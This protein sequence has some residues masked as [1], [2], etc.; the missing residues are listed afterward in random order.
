[1]KKFASLF[2]V[3]ALTIVFPACAK[4]AKKEEVKTEQTSVADKSVKNDKEEYTV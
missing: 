2:A 3:L 1:M 4:K